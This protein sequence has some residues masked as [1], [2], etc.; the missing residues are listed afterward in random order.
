MILVNSDILIANQP[1]CHRS[2]TGRHTEAVLKSLKQWNKTATVIVQNGWSPA[3]GNQCNLCITNDYLYN[4]AIFLICR[5]VT[6][7]TLQDSTF[8]Y[9]IFLTMSIFLVIQDDPPI[10]SFESWLMSTEKS[11][12][13]FASTATTS[14]PLRTSLEPPYLG[15]LLRPPKKSSP[16]MSR[17]I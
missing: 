2:A 7:R 12:A 8:C 13:L 3:T 9:T 5:G 15:R 1:L 14:L 10:P 4:L 11:S 6:V 16:C 17:G